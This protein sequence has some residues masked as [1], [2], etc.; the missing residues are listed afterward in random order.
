MSWIPI[1]SLCLYMASFSIGLGPVTYIVIS[2]LFSAKLR[3]F[4]MSVCIVVAWS[5]SFIIP[6]ASEPMMAALHTYG[7]FWFFASAIIL[8][9]VAVMVI[10]PETKGKT[11]SE[12]TEIFRKH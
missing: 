10:L 5:L 4:G 12:V 3:S 7:T 1:V 11:L 2:E 6:Y 8:G 9:F